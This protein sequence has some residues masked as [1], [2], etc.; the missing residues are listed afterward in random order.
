MVVA[1]RERSTMSVEDAASI[2]DEVNDYRSVFDE[3]M[4]I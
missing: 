3:K 2:V 1:E 4:P